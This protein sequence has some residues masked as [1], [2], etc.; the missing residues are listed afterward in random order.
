MTSFFL[1]KHRPGLFRSHAWLQAWLE[2][3][4]NHPEICLLEDK[5]TYKLSSVLFA[6]RHKIK[7][8]FP[9]KTAFPLGISTPAAASIR[10][11]YFSAD[12]PSLARDVIS[13]YIQA[14]KVGRCDQ[15]FLPDILQGSPE[16]HAVHDLSRE[17]G[18]D[19]IIKE[20]ASTYGVDVADGDF[21]SYLTQLGSNTRLKFYNRRKNLD[22][23][24]S[25]KIENIWPNQERFYELINSFH[26][27]RWGKPC[28]KDRN[29]QFMHVLLSY[30]V[31]DA[32]QVD[33]S[34]MSVGGNPVSVVLDI[35]YNGR[36]YNLQ[37]GYLEGFAKNISLGTLHYGYQIESA[38]ASADVDFYDF[39]A[40]TGKNSNYKSALANQEAQF[41]SFV[42]V[43]NPLLKIL[44]R[45]QKRFG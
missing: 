28:Y 45:L 35:R 13:G 14:M 38:F 30:L 6:Y 31:R 37:S 4:G 32:H 1:D 26:E 40:G 20:S 41:D 27:K 15:L 7:R 44:Y 42:L 18:L 39:M 17:Q 36:I 21:E 33:L 34:V 3:W 24:G 22:S 43:R 8:F 16:W 12:S 23:M 29:L 10:S 19:C 2:V 25:V 11:E 5:P 9:S